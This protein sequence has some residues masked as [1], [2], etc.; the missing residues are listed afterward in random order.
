M[1]QL[2]NLYSYFT[3]FLFQRWVLWVLF[4]VNFAGTIYGYIWYGNHLAATPP[5]LLIFVPDSPTASLFFTIFLGIYLFKQ[6]S[7]LIESLAAITS[8]KYGIWAIAMIFGGSWFSQEHANL[9]N[10]F[11]S[12]EPLDWMLVISHGGMA[13]QV[14][15]FTKLFSFR[16]IHL[17]IAALWTLIN[18]GFDYGLNTHP[19]LPFSLAEYVHFVGYF[20][21]A[22]SLLSIIIFSFSIRWQRKQL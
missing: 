3:D 10:M 8:F 17:F 16:P 5:H 14:L 20:T 18:D 6:K 9:R 11:E 19:Y 21:V 4:Y 1:N 13:V 2:K 7:P 22:L 12:I 15:I